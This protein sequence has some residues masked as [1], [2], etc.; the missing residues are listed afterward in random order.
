MERWQR[1]LESV[2][3]VGMEYYSCRYFEEHFWLVINSRLDRERKRFNYC[4]EPLMG[5]PRVLYAETEEETMKNFVSYRN[6]IIEESKRFPNK[7]DLEGRELTATCAKCKRWEKKEWQA[8]GLIH[9]ISLSNR[10]SPCQCRCVY[11]G[12]IPNEEA[13]ITEEARSGYEKMFANL[14][15]AKA[16][17][18]VAPD[19]KWTVACGEI[20]IHPYKDRILDLVEDCRASYF[21]NA[22]KYEERIAQKLKSSPESTLNCSLDSGTAETYKK[23]KGLDCFET[24]RNN[25]LRYYDKG[26]RPHQI[27]L[28]YIVL[29]GENDHDEDYVE[30]L[31]LAKEVS[32]EVQISCDERTKYGDPQ[33]RK[34]VIPAA[35]RLATMADEFGI[36]KISYTLF[37]EEEEIAVRQF[38]MEQIERQ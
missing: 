30:F 6:Q 28:K 27:Q 15:Y 37:T 22:C 20:T 14:E 7:E 10:P 17:G 24:V 18:Y 25:L 26:C 12:Y 35:A 13:I 5:L 16:N 34:K 3:G 32:A 11:C 1:T 29:P 2:E 21:T 23:I 33:E 8:D 36:E 4:C 31:Q 19:A 9:N 38:S